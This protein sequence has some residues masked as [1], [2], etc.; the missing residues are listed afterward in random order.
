MRSWILVVVA[1]ALSAAAPAA[2]AADPL[3]LGTGFYERCVSRGEAVRR[4]TTCLTF[5]LGM[6]E[7]MRSLS[8][9]LREQI[10]FD[11]EPHDTMDPFIAYL[12][13]NRDKLDGRTADLYLAAMAAA[14]PCGKRPADKRS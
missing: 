14:Y 10:C 9:H 2:R 12:R 4:M 13:R 3:E 7:S 1:A 8:R 11:G 6:H 5:V